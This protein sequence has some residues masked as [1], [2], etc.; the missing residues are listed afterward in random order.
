MK[1]GNG[2]EE[3]G[4]FEGKIR[5]AHSIERRRK[6]RERKERKGEMRGKGAKGAKGAKGDTGGGKE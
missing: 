2:G 5:L 1:G 4:R 6:V 3:L